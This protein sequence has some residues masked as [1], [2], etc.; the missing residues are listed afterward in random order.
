MALYWDAALEKKSSSF[1]E[2]SSRLHSIC[3][4]SSSESSSLF[5]QGAST[6]DRS[7]AV[8]PFFHACL[9]LQQSLRWLA[10]TENSQP[11]CRCAGAHTFRYEDPTFQQSSA[12]P[13]PVGSKSNKSETPATVP[14]VLEASNAGSCHDFWAGQQSTSRV[15]TA[16]LTHRHAT[17][18]ERCLAAAPFS[19]PISA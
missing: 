10:C 7:I 17:C 9:V 3:T 4:S 18:R 8:T 14:T 1:L 5:K 15:C 13:A 12:S 2:S 16:P 6:H 11:C 19:S